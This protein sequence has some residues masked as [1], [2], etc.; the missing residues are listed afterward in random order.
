MYITIK[1][2]RCAAIIQIMYISW[3]VQLK[4][5]LQESINFIISH[6]YMMMLM[7]VHDL[8]IFDDAPSILARFIFSYIFSSRSASHSK[9]SFT[10]CTSIFESIVGWW[11]RKDSVSF[12]Q[13]SSHKINMINLLSNIIGSSLK[14]WCMTT[15]TTTNALHIFKNNVHDN[16]YVY[17]IALNAGRFS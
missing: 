14:W 2:R 9:L 7:I 15:I 5:C 12:R 4:L 16:L 10:G 8:M 11:A 6:T 13:W 17:T 1:G 3:K